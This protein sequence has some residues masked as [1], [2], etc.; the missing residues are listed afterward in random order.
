MSTF[1]IG[2]RQIKECVHVVTDF[3][4]V[5]ANIQQNHFGVQIV[6]KVYCGMKRD[7]YTVYSYL[8]KVSNS[9]AKVLLFC[10]IPISFND[11]IK[12]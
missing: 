8:T 12:L 5:N 2:L 3:I 10:L 9:T 4:F 11:S 7:I 1:K 6:F